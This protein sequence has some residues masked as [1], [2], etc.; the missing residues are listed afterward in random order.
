MYRRFATR[1]VEEALADTPVVFLM[2]ARQVGKTTL[3]Q[4]M[5]DDRWE[6]IT[7]DDRAQ[8]EIARADPVGF[9]RNLPPKRIALDEVQRVPGTLLAI[10][11]A[12]DED[13]T[14]GRF[15]LTGSANAMLLPKLSGALVGRMEAVRLATLSEC[16]LTG[17]EPTFLGRMLRL[18]MPVATDLR[19]R[20]HLARRI[21]AGGFPEPL[22]RASEWRARAWHQQ[23]VGTLVQR[24]LAELARIKHLDAMTKLLE[25]TALYSG[26]LVNLTELGGRLG[27]NR[28]TVG[29]YL[30]LLEQLFLVER[31][32]AWHTS[33]FKRLVKAPKIHAADTG[34]I[35]AL[36][37][38]TRQ[39]LLKRPGDLGSLLESFVYNE[40]RKQALWVGEPLTFHHYRD[41]D[42]LEIDIIIETLSGR[43]F[44]IEVKAAAGLA[45]KDFHALRR[46]RSVAGD[47]FGAGILLYDGDHSTAFGDR[48]FAV[49]VGALWAGA[50]GPGP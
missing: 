25:L 44:A 1:F 38:I 27:L 32:P 12:V 47:R 42:K 39:G 22:A 15:L 13:R 46:F 6:Y 17:R 50:T 35:C 8:L 31:L 3:V 14:P 18:E 21:V 10:K 5:I 30:A 49:P 48:L 26:R 16:E 28:V 41:K 40:L 20:D 45:A 34:M 4:M 19:V 9:I 7:F 23:Y 37:G 24:D 29:K 11:Q 33:E 2:G 36:R 43:C